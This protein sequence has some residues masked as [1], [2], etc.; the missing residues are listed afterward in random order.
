MVFQ[1]FL[2]LSAADSFWPETFTAID[3]GNP[4]VNPKGLKL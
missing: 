4:K 1:L 3:R 2:T